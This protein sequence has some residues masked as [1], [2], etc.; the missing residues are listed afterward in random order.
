MIAY[1]PYN[2]KLEKFILDTACVFDLTLNSCFDYLVKAR[3]SD[4]EIYE[5]FLKILEKFK[6]PEIG[7]VRILTH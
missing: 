3:N 5:L 2:P 1:I 4:S 6:N 7:F